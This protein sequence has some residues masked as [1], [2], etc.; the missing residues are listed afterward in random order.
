MDS[1]KVSTPDTRSRCGFCGLL[2]SNWPVRV[3]HLAEHFKQGYD[4]R[5]WRGDWGFD[6]RILAMVENAIPPCGY[7]FRAGTAYL[8]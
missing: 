6:A 4:M 2:L 5:S 1:W 8:L 7:P 3:D